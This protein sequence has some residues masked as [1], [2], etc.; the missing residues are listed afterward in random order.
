M[1]EK[2][3]QIGALSRRESLARLGGGA[4]LLASSLVGHARLARAGD[5]PSASSAPVAD[6]KSKDVKDCTEGVEL[7]EQSKRMRK[8]LQYVS[9]SSKPDKYCSN[10]SQWIPPEGEGP[11]GGCKLFSGPVNANGYCLSWAPQRG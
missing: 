9:K 10:C 11:C 6:D 2:P 4:M 7:S 8:T 1:E 3:I 5:P